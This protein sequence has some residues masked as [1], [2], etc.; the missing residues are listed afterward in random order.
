MRVEA[1]SISVAFPGKILFRQLDF[2]IE[3]GER[4]AILGPNGSGKSTVI[5]LL[6]GQ[7]RP[8][9]GRVTYALGERVLEV[10]EACFRMGFAAPYAEL[11]EEL[12]VAE[13]FDFQRGF[14]PFRNHLDFGAFR[15]LLGLVLSPNQRVSSLSS[16]MKQRL[17]L[18][19]AVLS[20]VDLLLLDEPCSNLDTTG[21]D[22]YRQLLA[23]HL[24]GRS[25][26]VGSNH[27]PEEI[28]L[29]TRSL[30]LAASV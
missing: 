17:K 21:R 15:T 18:A 1:Q 24:D 27:V 10:E 29:C 28:A 2:A 7:L 12:T 9:S 14:R 19:L 25:L 23:D 11:I 22:W 30:E 6:L 4:V 16:G 3:S 5:K 20:E 13:H 26:V 8:R